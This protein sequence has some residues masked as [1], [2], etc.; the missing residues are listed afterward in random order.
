[1]GGAE[2]KVHFNNREGTNRQELLSEKKIT[3]VLSILDSRI[4]DKVS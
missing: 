1:M 2:C 3:H 4:E